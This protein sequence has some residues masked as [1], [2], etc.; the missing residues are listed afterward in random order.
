MDRLLLGNIKGTPGNEGKSA[1]ELA[2]MNG[3]TGTEQ[4]WLESLKGESGVQGP[5]GPAGTYDILDSSN[6]VKENM[7]AG[8]IVDALVIKE[9]FQSVSEGK[10]ILA[11][12]ITDMGVPTDA[13]ETFQNMAENIGA[14]I[15]GSG[16]GGGGLEGS[17]KMY[18]YGSGAVK[19]NQNITK[20][21]TLEEKY[22]CALGVLVI[23]SS[24]A[25]P[26]PTLILNNIVNGD[27]ACSTSIGSFSLI[28][29]LALDTSIAGLEPGDQYTV[30]YSFNA[31]SSTNEVMA[32][33]VL[34]IK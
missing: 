11:S 29:L 16:G 14:I 32:C 23:S 28:M 9:V 15:S 33:R 19:S 31:S 7:E 5:E 10:A 3:F 25:N 13:S 1:Y 30:K 21:I 17:C 8:K 27:R 20:T 26:A 34:L 6:A 4:D 12:A 22:K 2:V 18:S 24:L